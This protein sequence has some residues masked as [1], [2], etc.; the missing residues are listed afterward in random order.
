MNL[1]A[2]RSSD[3]P[4]VHQS[5]TKKTPPLPCVTV[6]LNLLETGGTRRIAFDFQS[7]PVG[8]NRSYSP[9]SYQLRFKDI[10]SNHVHRQGKVSVSIW[11]V[12]II[13][14]HFQRTSALFDSRLPARFTG[15]CPAR[16]VEILLANPPEFSRK[17]MGGFYCF[18][19]CD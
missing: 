19:P 12:V 4:L 6:P 2:D 7:R 15:L 13:L 1:V 14:R 18:T 16:F 9:L 17:K 10:V 5:S 8:H 11:T 3:N